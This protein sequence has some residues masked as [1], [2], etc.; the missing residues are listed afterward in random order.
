MLL[1][2][3]KFYKLFKDPEKPEDELIFNWD[4]EKLLEVKT[5]K[6]S[7]LCINGKQVLIDFSQSIIKEEWFKNTEENISIIGKRGDFLR[8]IKNLITGSS[9]NT[10]KSIDIFKK[11][12]YK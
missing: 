2:I 1:P 3:K 10:S 4:N 9:N 7:F 6:K 8:K 5:K 11:N 12:L